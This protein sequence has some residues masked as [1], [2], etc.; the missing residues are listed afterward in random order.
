MTRRGPTLPADIE[1]L[2]LRALSEK[3][4]PG[5][6]AD[7]KARVMV[8]VAAAAREEATI[9]TVRCAEGEWRAIGGGV[10]V[11]TLHDNGVTRTWLAR[12][13]PGA[14]V[15][16]HDH[17]GDEE[18]FVL[19]GSVMLDEI[20]LEAGD[21][22]VAPRGSHHSIVASRNGCLVLMRTPA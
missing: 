22:Q 21:Y 15:P 12:M 17:D 8:R 19:E 6:P 4:V 3:G 14:T 16:A 9:V 11:K 2:L 20:V 5:V 13:S 10:E 1:E 7:L 18:I